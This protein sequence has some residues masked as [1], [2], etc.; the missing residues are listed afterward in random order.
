RGE[1]AAILEFEAARRLPVWS[2]NTAAVAPPEYTSRNAA[3]TLHLIH[4]RGGGLQ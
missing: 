3:S 1:E 4:P 2:L